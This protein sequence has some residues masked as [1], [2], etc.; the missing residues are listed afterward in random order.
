MPRRLINLPAGLVLA[1]GLLP[2]PGVARAAGNEASAQ[3]VMVIVEENRNRG[4]VIGAGD[5]PYL[6]SL[7]NRYTDTTSWEGVGH[8][9]LPNYLAL[10]SGSTQG[11]TE[12][13]TSISFPGIPTLGSQ[14]SEAGIPWKAYLEGMPEVASELATSG[15][16]AKKHN[17]FAYFPGTNGPNVVPASQF[18]ADLAE[19]KLPSFVWYTPN[20]INDGH[21]GSNA[22]V[23]HSLEGIVAPVL[24]SA[25][26][27]AGATI[28]ITWDESAAEPNVIPTVLISGEGS[29]TPFTTKGNHYGTLAAI[30]DLYGLPRLGNAA[31]AT[32][33]PLARASST[34]SAGTAPTATTQTPTLANAAQSNRVWREG[35]ALARLARRRSLPAVGTT[36]SF[37]L[38]VA[39]SV[40]FAF[41]QQLGGRQLKGRC[42]AP[43][44]RNRGRRACRRTV[45][46]GTLVFAAHAGTNRVSFQ[47]RISKSRKLG[48][49]GYVVAIT[50]ANAAGRRSSPV[51]LG[52]TIVR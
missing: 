2:A 51:R 50:A 9:S 44:K 5:M 16:Y 37:T 20:L 30:E 14:L 46:Q 32:P 52:F 29:R 38:N 26:Y 6:N 17:P 8:P 49:G 31:R 41:T 43:S 42:V 12:D 25:W 40:G 27:K 24:G 35:P 1:L 3:H 11:V 18:A 28:I 21:D 10:I 22:D 13:L 19:G 39:A 7:A 33:L 45:T 48:P 34:G 15:E 23:D 4:E 36:F 47:G